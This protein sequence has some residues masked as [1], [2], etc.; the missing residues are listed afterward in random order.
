M[1]EQKQK[2]LHAKINADL[3][4]RLRARAQ[5]LG[6]TTL[7]SYVIAVLVASLDDTK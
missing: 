4:K 6:F 7:S 1:E 2:Y 3:Y 5:K